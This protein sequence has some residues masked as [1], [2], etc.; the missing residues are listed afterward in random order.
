MLADGARQ[1]Q[2]G[3]L[4]IFGGQWDRIFAPAV[5]TSHPTMAVVLVLQVEYTEALKEHD[6]EL[7]LR[8]ADGEPV[9]PKGVA[10][11]NVGHPPGLE[12]GAPVS[13]PLTM[14]QQGI[15]FDSY[16]RFEWL[17]EVD[18]RE[19]GRLPIAVAQMQSPTP[20]AIPPPHLD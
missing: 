16:G 2:D 1:G 12:P 9:G 18:G 11:F 14:E 6:L 5:P 17:I 15:V 20:S 13:F 10:R 4:Y 8:R 19:M 7:T 3:K